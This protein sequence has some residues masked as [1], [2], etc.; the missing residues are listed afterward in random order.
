[1]F[2]SEPQS[3]TAGQS[4]PTV[5]AAALDNTGAITTGF[6]GSVSVAIAA[7]PSGGSLSDTTTVSAINGVATFHRLTI[8]RPGQGY[9]LRAV[10]PGTTLAAA[11]SKPFDVAPPPPA[12]GDLSVTTTTG[13]SN[14]PTSDYTVTIDGTASQSIHPNG[15]ASF[16][17]L[18]SGTHT[19]ALSAV[20]ANC[21]VSGGNSRSVT[22]AAGTTA[23]TTFAVS[24]SSQTGSLMVTTSTTG[25]TLPTGYTFAV[26][27]GT[28]QAI[29]I[30]GSATVAG[31]SALSHTVTLNGVPNNCTVSGGT[32]QTV[33]VPA[34]GTGTATFSV[35]C[36]APAGSLTVTTST[37]GSNPPTGYT[38]AV[39][40]GTGQAIGLTTSVTV[41]GLGAG[42]HTVT[43][44]GVPSNCTV[45]GGTSQTVTVPAGGTA[46]A[47]FSVSCVAPT[48]SLTVT[49]STTGSNPPTGYTFAVDGGTGQA[50]GLTTSV[51]VPGLSAGSHTVTLSG[52]PSNCTVSG[53]NPQTV[54][55]PA[56]GTATAAFSVSC[57]PVPPVVT[58]PAT[59]HVLVGLLYTVPASFTD[60][61]NAGPWTFTVDWGD[62]TLTRGTAQQPGP[63]NA[64]HTYIL[65][66]YQVRVTVVNSAGAS[67]SATM[68]LSVP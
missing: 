25:T 58:M 20:P 62:G 38:F 42:S 4:L 13:G 61:A 68:V 56:G 32:S 40:G 63:I 19:V 9:T 64:T 33:T 54:T 6:A 66:T 7:N 34:G 47:A 14:P 41:S 39:D 36:V 21:V 3:A 5:R 48:G 30:N 50:I 11:E 8:D 55:V 22:V 2:T 57:A 65:G 23:S 35:S 52:V 16:P 24:C 67:G 49:T 15:T 45:S 43:L 37:T 12:T 60:A 31:L 53:G 27:G 17:G 18:A 10:A 59:D 28:G 44:N 1:V 46:T 26:D 51:T 29:G